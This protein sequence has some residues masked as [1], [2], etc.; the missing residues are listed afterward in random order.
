MLLDPNLTLTYIALATALALAPGP[1]MLFVIANGMRHSVKGA[2][3]S[4]L[5]IGAG[6]LIHAITAALGLS[7][8]I[9]ASPTA[10]EALRIIGALYL[11]LLGLRSLYA[12]W[13]K[14]TGPTTSATPPQTPPQKI[15]IQGLITN[16]FNPK[17]VVFYIALLPQFIRLDLGHIGLQLFLLGCIHNIIGTA[18]L[19]CVGIAAG[20]AA[21][22]LSTSTFGRWMDGI[23][24]LFFIGLALRIA[25]TPRPG[26]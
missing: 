12:C 26:P 9:A 2:V 4:A 23:A 20:R 13:R 3:T 14:Q 24:G 5:G 7:A 10:F 11:G 16:L 15:F 8:I 17:M 19:L 1:D 25:L 21:H 6:S 18:I 22:W